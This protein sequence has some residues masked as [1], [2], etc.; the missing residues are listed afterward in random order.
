MNDLAAQKPGQGARRKPE[1]CGTFHKLA[2]MFKGLQ[3]HYLA[4]IG[5]YDKLAAVPTSQDP[6]SMSTQ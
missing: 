1:S 2:Q 3:L 6:W 5:L 4:I